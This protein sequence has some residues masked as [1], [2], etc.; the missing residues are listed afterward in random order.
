MIQ[1]GDVESLIR[2][3]LQAGVMEDGRYEKTNLG[4][5]QGGNL[6]PLL[7]NVMLNE[8][9]KELEKRGLNLTRYADDRVIAVKSEFSAIRGMHSVTGWIG[10]KL[11]LKV[12]ATKTHV[13]TPSKLKYL[14]Y[15]FYKDPSVKRWE[16]RPHQDSKDKFKAKL[17]LLCCRS[18]S[19]DFTTKVRKLNEVI[20]GWINYFIIGKMKTVLIGIDEHLRTMLRVV[21]WKQ[22]KVPSKREWGL[23]KLGI[24][25][26]LARCTA[27][28]GNRYYW[29]ATKTCL[30][31]AVSKAILTRRGLVSCVDYYADRRHTLQLG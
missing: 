17:K 27:Y 4:T 26:D 22:W 10:K 1:D 21:I 7:S 18:W 11:G 24:G 16:A 14:G 15:D 20:R 3:Y 31:R 29:V 8:M 30:S 2:K 9:D 19:I 28:C 6:S 13:T 5:P 23:K 25:K 12:N